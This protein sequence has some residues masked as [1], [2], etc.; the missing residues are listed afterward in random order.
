MSRALHHAVERGELSWAREL[1][2]SNPGLVFSRGDE[3]RTPLHL[4]R[5]E[6]GPRM[7]PVW[8]ARQAF[9][10]VTTWPCQNWCTGLV[11]PLGASSIGDLRWRMS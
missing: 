4:V 10:W 8:G 11:T 6:R 5:T 2:E 1:V 9:G 7:L 3:N